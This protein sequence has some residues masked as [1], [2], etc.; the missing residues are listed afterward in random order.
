M[1]NK[2][3]LRGSFGNIGVCDFVTALSW[4]VEGRPG[5]STWLASVL[6]R[7]CVKVSLHRS[8]LLN[9]CFPPCFTAVLHVTEEQ[10]VGSSEWAKKKAKRVQHKKEAWQA[11]I[12]D[13][14]SKFQIT[15]V[16]QEIGREMISVTILAFRIFSLRQK[17]IL[18]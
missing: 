12:H 5:L 3:L 8:H 11:N 16:F 10:C 13:V 7:C 18:V 4:G 15:L 9:N 2:C 14:T 1:W 6:L 17:A